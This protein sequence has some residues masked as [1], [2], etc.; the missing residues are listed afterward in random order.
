MFELAFNYAYIG[1]LSYQW[2]VPPPAMELLKEKFSVEMELFASPL[3]HFNSRFY[4]LFEMDRQF[5]GLGNC[6]Q[7]KE[8]SGA[9]Y[10]ANP[11]FIENI[12]EL[13]AN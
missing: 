3:N 9:G 10:E 7:A 5:G 2:C 11:P 13:N 1:G 12:M 6:L 4:S 8:L